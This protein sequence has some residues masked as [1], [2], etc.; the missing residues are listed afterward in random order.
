MKQFVSCLVVLAALGAVARGEQNQ[1]QD[2]GVKAAVEAWAEAY[3]AGDVEKMAALYSNSDRVTLITSTGKL[4][5]GIEGARAMYK[6]DF[7]AAKRNKITLNDMFV[8]QLG[9]IAW[10]TFKYTA[11]FAKTDD[12]S[13]WQLN[14]RG[15][16]VLKKEDGKW[17]IVQEH[18][19]PRDDIERLTPVKE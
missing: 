1:G 5:K 10:V 18:F 3:K 14:S 17:K 4:I 16:M 9:D 13:K 15:T 2:N 19:S 6:V 12:N 7:V 8:N 11:D